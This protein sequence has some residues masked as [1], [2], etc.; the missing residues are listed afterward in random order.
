[1]AQGR[2]GDRHA[3]PG[4]LRRCVGLDHDLHRLYCLVDLDASSMYV[5]GIDE[6]GY[7]LLH[8]KLDALGPGPYSGFLFHCY[9]RAQMPSD[10]IP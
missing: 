1:M 6:A 8:H 9:S 4:L 7:I 2:T 3:E 10:P 5:C